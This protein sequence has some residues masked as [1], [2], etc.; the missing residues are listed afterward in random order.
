M[1][2]NLQLLVGAMAAVVLFLHALEGFSAELQAAGGDRLRRWLGRAT[3]SRWRGFAIG[4]GATAV[5]QSSSAVSSM[6]V[7]LVNSGA[8]SF[9][10]SLAILIGANV[11]TT[12]TAWL[13]SFKLTGI[14]PWAI[15]LGTLL[16]ALGSERWRC[17][18]KPVFYFG[19]IFFSLD[20]I[21]TALQPLQASALWQQ[22]LGRVD[23]LP[24][25][26]LAGALMTA[27][28]QSSSVTVGI[29]ILLVQQQLLAPDAAIAAAIG[30]NVGTTATGLLASLR[31]DAAARRTALANLLFNLAGVLA[32]SPLLASFA[33]LALRMGETPALAV[34][35][36]HLLFN[37]ATALLTL[38]LLGPRGLGGWIDRRWPEPAARP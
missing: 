20:L 15:V 33:G 4:A 5:V 28:L 8:L 24:A 10:G 13:V 31:M 14:G 21:S 30:A 27:L 29:A 32:I 26:L 12:V 2:L 23:A 17:V 22:A 34:A 18:G 25:A 16:S 38:P 9:R 6:A 36:A 19:F 11:G 3:A 1:D 37:C 7:A 35:W